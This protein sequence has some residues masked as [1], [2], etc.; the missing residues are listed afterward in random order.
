M[1]A[2]A[3]RNLKLYLRDKEA[4][5][6]SLLA[7]FIIIGLYVLFLGDVYTKDLN[8]VDHAREIMDNWIMAGVL[9]VT[10]F[11]TAFSVLSY[12]VKDKAEKIVMDF[13]SS[14]VR[15]KSLIGGYFLSAYIIGTLMTF[16]ALILAECYIRYN[17]GSFMTFHV[18]VKVAL[19]IILVSFMNTGITLFIVSFFKSTGAFSAAVTVV[20]T[21]IGFITGIYLPIGMFPSA[22]QYII[23]VFP[24]S[25]GAVMFRQ[26]MMNDLMESAF[27]DIPA[28]K[29]LD[30]KEHLGVIF[31]FSDNIVTINQNIMVMLFTSVVFIF[32]SYLILLRKN[33]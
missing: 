8:D 31:K 15:K 33:K 28:D 24:V 3:K 30:I 5:F 11:T 4:V 10:S 14:P 18:F 29:I 1:I 19:T 22:V 27:S 7:V 20:G 16:L 12:L 32:L 21:V 2:F 13:L 6:F 26:F 17:G 9:A 23:K 25:H